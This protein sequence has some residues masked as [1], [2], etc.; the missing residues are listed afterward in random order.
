MKSLFQYADSPKVG[1][2]KR[3]LGAPSF[4]PSHYLKNTF[5]KK[6]EEEK[7]K[8]ILGDS[9]KQNRFHHLNSSTP[10]GTSLEKP[11]SQGYAAISSIGSG[12]KREMPIDDGDRGAGLTNHELMTQRDHNFN[13][14]PSHN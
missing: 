6:E 14:E 8:S 12:K 11:V 7:P 4:D 9:I 2:R 13:L 3:D 5:A 10:W 1:R